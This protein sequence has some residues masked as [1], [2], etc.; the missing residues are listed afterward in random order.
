MSVADPTALRSALVTPTLRVVAA[1]GLEGA[2][3][4]EGSSP[5]GARAFL[6]LIGRVAAERIPYHLVAAIESGALPATDE[7]YEEA[8]RCHESAL[9]VDVCLERVLAGISERLTAAGIDHR[10]LKG[11][12]VA[13]SDYDDPAMRSS[14]DVDLLVEGKHLDAAVEMLVT[15]GGRTLFLEPRPGFRARFEKGVCVER[16]DGFEVDVHR[17]FCSGP[18]GLSLVAD[19][20]FDDHAEVVLGGT[21]VPVLGRTQRFLHVCYHAALSKRPR[22]SSL[23][24]IAEIDRSGRLNADEVLE[25]SRRWR[26]QAA[27]ARGLRVT[28]E[29]LGVELDGTLRRWADSYEPTRFEAAALRAY[30]SEE[31]SYARQAA[32]GLWAIR[33]W[34]DRAAYARALLLP[35]HE[36]LRAREGSLSM[37]WRHA[38][39][40]GRPGRR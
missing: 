18:F 23:R 15:D 25:T 5:L 28:S 7:Q 33:S 37:R 6:E 16:E 4:A 24:D 38:I 17:V 9:A 12:A 21:A 1:Q 40:L 34:R 26:G 14:G 31:G 8:K 13:H 32:L 3:V 10:A 19:D 27:V 35:S 36:Y 39:N 30:A 22:L 11:M 2:P 29:T 20:L